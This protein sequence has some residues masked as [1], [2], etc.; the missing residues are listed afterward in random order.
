MPA[1]V[2]GRLET[3]ASALE[4]AIKTGNLSDIKAKSEA[5]N[6]VWNEAS[7]K[8]YE[9]VKNQPG[10]QPGPDEQGPQGGQPGGQQEG[11]SGD[12]GKKVENADFEVMDDK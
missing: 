7:T 12:G 10:A 5:L 6:A 4:E 9:S 2:K 3:A 8:M 1:D 11:Q